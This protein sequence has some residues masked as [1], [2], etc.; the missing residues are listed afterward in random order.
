MRIRIRI[1]IHLPGILYTLGIQVGWKACAG[2][3]GLTQGDLFRLWC[4]LIQ[5]FFWSLLSFKIKGV[6]NQK[7]N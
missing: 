5:F 2:R 3:E 6:K 1:R 4:S 7:I